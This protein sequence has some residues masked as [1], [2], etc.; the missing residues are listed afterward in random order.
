MVTKMY[1]DSHYLLQIS[2]PFQWVLLE[3]HWGYT[4]N[5]QINVYICTDSCQV[6][7]F[8]AGFISSL[9]SIINEPMVTFL[10]HYLLKV[11]NN[12]K[13]LERE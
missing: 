9:I 4:K 6:N 10:N 12:S 11:T 2:L 1:S 8:S 5:L 7:I 13:I 3:F